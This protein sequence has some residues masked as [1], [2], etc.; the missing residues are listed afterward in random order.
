MVVPL[1]LLSVELNRTVYIGLQY[2]LF[3]EV[4]E[5]GE[6]SPC[7]NWDIGNKERKCKSICIGKNA[8]TL[9]AKIFL[10]THYGLQALPAWLTFNSRSWLP[11]GQWWDVVCYTITAMLQAASPSSS[12][13]WQWKNNNMCCITWRENCELWYPVLTVFCALEHLVVWW[14]AHPR[15]I[16]P[17]RNV[18]V[19]IQDGCL[20]H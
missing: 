4:R 7:F 8:N 19:A 15:G 17:E 16:D 14:W 9:E 1:Q 3:L 11:L 6:Y 12:T 10:V 20:L 5:E 2:Q 18:L 13:S